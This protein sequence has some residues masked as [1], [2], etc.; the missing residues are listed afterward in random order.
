MR[1]N[2]D[3]S[4]GDSRS[5]HNRISTPHG[6]RAARAIAAGGAVLLL[7]TIIAGAASAVKGNRVA[8]PVLRI[9]YNSA[10]ISPNPALDNCCA[11][12]DVG[13]SLAYEPILHLR[14]DG[15]VAPGLATSW[16]FVKTTAGP[17]K[18]FEFTLRHNASFSNGQPVTADAVR[19]WLSYYA[20]ANGPFA[21][22]FGPNPTFS[23]DGG[24]TVVVQTENPTPSMP[25]LLS[26][27]RN[28][29][30]V[31]APAAVADP[32]AFATASYGAGPY[33]LDPS[34]TV[35]GDHYTF[36]PNPYYYDKSKVKWSEVDVKIIT[37]P[38][39]M[40]TALQ[41]GQLDVA[42]GDPST[43]SAARSSGFA[44]YWASSG[45]CFLGLDASGRSAPLA[46]IRVR[47][48]LSYAIDRNALEK[49][50]FGGYALPTSEFVT[51]D[52]FDPKYRNY[53]PYNPAKA[54]ALLAAAGY[55]NGFSLN[56]LGAPGYS[57]FDQI[58]ASYFNAVGVKVNVA[59]APNTSVFV[60]QLAAATSPIFQGCAQS[61]PYSVVLY[62][63]VLRP[64]G[65][66]NPYKIS[67]PVINHLFYTGLKSKDPS[68][69]FE[70]IS[71]RV[72]EQA[73]QM[74]LVT[75]TQFWYATTKVGGVSPTNARTGQ[76]FASEWYPK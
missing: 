22:V 9:G 43:V 38:S 12:T 49:T 65:F 25:F 27:M 76:T 19:N 70:Q 28:A 55:P 71:R 20:S 23:V 6:A 2:N 33:M 50:V 15:T 63:N 56:L 53:Y 31:A 57:N 46:D 60:Q 51:T 74:P 37:V 4:I 54:T 62:P 36:V 21:S 64:S 59:S 66:Y 5:D 34:R 67:D 7:L 47:Q 61:L 26:E 11:Q 39:T 68:S 17:N 72:V 29:G 48:A 35:S 40:L 13:L 1:R 16:G 41:S 44:V 8:N 73:I 10:G 30:Y 24:W 18:K 14:T 42:G 69:D 3:D 32:T 52:G 75:N 58:V 45:T